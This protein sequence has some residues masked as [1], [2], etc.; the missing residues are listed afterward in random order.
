MKSPS[1]PFENPP[2]SEVLVSTYFNP[3][4]SDLRNEHIGLFWAEIKDAFPSVL[5]Q[6]LVGMGPDVIV[7]ETFPMPRY[8]FIA[9]DDINL[10]QIQRNAFMFNWR[11]RKEEHP[12]FYNDIKPTFDKFHGIFSEFIR[13][14][15][16]ANELTVDLCELAYI[17]TLERCEY[18]A[19]PQDTTK[20]IP[21]FSIL[22]LDVDESESA[23]FNCNYACE[24]STDMQLKVGIRSGV[25]TN[26]QNAPVL[27]FEIRASGRLG[28]V[29]KSRADEWFERSHVAITKCFLD[30]TNREIQN[31]YW[32]PVEKIR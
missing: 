2:V 18:W 9:E 27:I 19:G 31:R 21:S 29:E 4:L 1:I 17:N 22:K 13:R 5:Q 10:I 24:I 30:I 23:E 26:Q 8:W 16:D 6:P 14:E 15:L 20:V 11:R 3:P 32:K 28:Q 12:L 25:K 7:G